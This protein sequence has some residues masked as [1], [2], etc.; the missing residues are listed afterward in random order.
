MPNKP[1]LLQRR[2]G[3]PVAAWRL[4]R[5][6]AARPLGAELAAP[7]ASLQPEAAPRA[8]AGAAGAAL[9]DQTP[10]MPPDLGSA[11]VVFRSSASASACRGSTAKHRQLG[12]HARDEQLT[13]WNAV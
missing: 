3:C 6:G 7:P 1:P 8:R 12:G 2:T 5:S 9:A 13:T 10:P 4:L 11:L